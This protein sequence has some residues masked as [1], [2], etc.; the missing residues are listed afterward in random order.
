MDYVVFDGYLSGACKFFCQERG[1]EP[2]IL[3]FLAPVA[4]TQPPYFLCKLWRFC[5]TAGCL[6]S[7]ECLSDSFDLQKMTIR[8]FAVSNLRFLQG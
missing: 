1:Q 6:A 4:T 2:I 8:F 7:D 5:R 3:R